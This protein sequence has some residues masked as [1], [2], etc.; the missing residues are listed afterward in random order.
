MPSNEAAYTQHVHKGMLLN[1][2]ENSYPVPEVVL[3]EIRDALPNMLLNRYPDDSYSELRNAYAAWIGVDADQIIAGNGSDQML[4]L[5]IGSLCKNCGPLLTLTPDFGMYD[6]YASSYGAD[7]V[8]YPIDLLQGLDVKDFVETARDVKPGLVLFSNPNNPTGTM[9][10]KED[11]KEI[12]DALYPTPV[13]LDEAYMEFGNDSAL[14]LLESTPNLYITRTLSKAFGMAGIRC[15]FL[16]SSH[17]NI[18]KLLPDKIVYNLSNMTAHTAAIVLKHADLYEAQVE[19]I[20]N[21]RSKMKAKLES[22]GIVCGPEHANYLCL[23]PDDPQKLAALF[24]ANDIAVRTYPGKPYMRLT[25]G[26]PEENAQVARLLE[27]AYA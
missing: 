24:E 25:I 10:A 18:K 16:L 11:V 12:A 13:V 9:I 17:D 26:T 15:G 14:P 4:Q 22:L 27:E 23:Y 2:N 20:I 21:E 1:A 6:F 7:V 5:L 19:E 3:E 8:K